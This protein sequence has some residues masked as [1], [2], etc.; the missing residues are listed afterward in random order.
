MRVIK[1]TS[2]YVVNIQYVAVTF[3]QLITDQTH[4]IVTFMLAKKKYKCRN[5]QLKSKF[6]VDYAAADDA[7]DHEADD[8]DTAHTKR[9]YTEP[10]TNKWTIQINERTNK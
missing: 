3:M 10:Q 5:E 1:Y 2:V 9:N 7:G 6:S 4:F 8:A